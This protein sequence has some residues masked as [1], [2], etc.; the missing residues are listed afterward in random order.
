MCE[1]SPRGRFVNCFCVFFQGMNGDDGMNGTQGR[2]GVPGGP[3]PDGPPGPA[4]PEGPP[5]RLGSP[6]KTVR[7]KYLFSPLLICMCLF[8]V[9]S[10]GSKW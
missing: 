7:K 3:G 9:G 1:F 5:G 6:G 10:R 2:K 8:P 4:G